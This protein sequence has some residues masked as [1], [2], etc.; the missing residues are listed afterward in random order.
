ME[1]KGCLVPVREE[2]VVLGA[3]LSCLC[4]KRGLE[5]GEPVKRGAAGEVEPDR[6]P[7]GCRSAWQKEGD[8]C[9]NHP[10]PEWR[11]SLGLG[12]ALG[13]LEESLPDSRLLKQDLLLLP[14][15]PTR[16]RRF[17]SPGTWLLLAGSERPGGSPGGVGAKMTSEVAAEAS[18]SCRVR[19]QG[20]KV[21]QPGLEPGEFLELRRGETGR[22]IDRGP[23]RIAIR[24]QRTRFI[25][26]EG[27]APAPLRLDRDIPVPPAPAPLA[28][29]AASSG[30]G[31]LLRV[32]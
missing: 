20:L 24:S 23:A 7:M 18:V 21:R 30:P 27:A 5:P 3:N 11:P 28:R 22:P 9:R 16:E 29:F 13:S 1:K 17:L 14:G 19:S 25:P 10:Q 26:S 4:R 32:R 6:K 15:K 31:R 12:E 8:R 2:E